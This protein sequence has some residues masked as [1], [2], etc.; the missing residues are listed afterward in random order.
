MA[1][2]SELPQSFVE[3]NNARLSEEYFTL[4][5]MYIVV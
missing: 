5:Y 4:P 1:E 2:F 3:D